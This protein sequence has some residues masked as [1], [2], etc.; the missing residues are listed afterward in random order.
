MTI[1]PIGYLGEYL[2]LAGLRTLVHR[3]PPSACT[4]HEAT[5][6]LSKDHSQESENDADRHC[7]EEGAVPRSLMSGRRMAW[8]WA[9][10][11]GTEGPL[12]A[13]DRMGTCD[14]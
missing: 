13:F 5:E 3:T 9:V 8:L 7:P 12:S 6:E 10:R 4:R 2:A 11:S 1:A 14:P